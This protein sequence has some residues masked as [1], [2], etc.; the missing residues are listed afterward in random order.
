MSTK[1]KWYNDRML[2]TQLIIIPPIFFYGLY[3]TDAIPVRHKK[4]ITIS[5]L[6]L[7]TLVIVYFLNQ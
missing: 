6:I 3:Y 5:F 2:L 7:L 4:I 1:E